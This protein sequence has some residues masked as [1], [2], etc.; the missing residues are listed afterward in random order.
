MVNDHQ[1]DKV[2]DLSRYLQWLITIPIA[3]APS[4]CEDT[5]KHTT[6]GAWAQQ[7][8]SHLPTPPARGCSGVQLSKLLSLPTQVKQLGSGSSSALPM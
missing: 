1:V 2:H 4:Q 6:D 8:L 5:N 3:A 7:R